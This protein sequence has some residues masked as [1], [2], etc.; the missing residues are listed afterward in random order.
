MN[1]WYINTWI[2]KTRAFISFQFWKCCFSV[3]KMLQ[4]SLLVISISCN[5]D[6]VAS[7][8]DE[9]YFVGEIWV[10]SS[11][12]IFTKNWL[13]LSVINILSVISIK[14]IINLSG[15]SELTYDVPSLF[16]IIFALKNSILLVMLFIKLFNFFKK[17]F[18]MFCMF[19]FF[20]LKILQNA[21]A[22]F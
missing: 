7:I 9:K 6:E 16:N 10:A 12:P 4:T 3:L 22:T 21:F 8:H 13:N 17:D 14:L 11:G 19:R 5:V 20:S 1:T 18:C 15:K 2:A